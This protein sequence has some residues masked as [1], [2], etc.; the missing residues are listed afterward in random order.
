MSVELKIKSKHLAL[1]PAIIRKEEYK[2]LEQMKWYKKHHQLVSVSLLDWYQNH[3]DLFKLHDKATSLCNHRKWNV[4]NEARAT[5]LARAYLAG[6]PYKSVEKKSKIDH[7]FKVYILP[8]VFDMV[9]KYGPNKVRK[10]WTKDKFDY[11]PEDKEKLMAE[12]T[13]WLHIE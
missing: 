9:A 8:R 10:Y 13:A 3:P 4:R 7:S 6:T 2:L 1:E 11:R 12:L 5:Y